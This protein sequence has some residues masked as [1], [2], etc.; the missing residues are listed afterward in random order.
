M[1]QPPRSP[2]LIASPPAT[3][4]NSPELR[5]QTRSGFARQGME[6]PLGL[7]GFTQQENAMYVIYATRR[8]VT[9]RFTYESHAQYCRAFFMLQAMGYKLACG[10]LPAY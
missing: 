10:T 4:G 6:S 5:P 7:F 3:S 8:G 1:P 2:F 9:E